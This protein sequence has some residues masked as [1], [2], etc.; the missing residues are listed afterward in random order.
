LADGLTV[1]LAPTSP[2]LRR[3]RLIYTSSDPDL[4]AVGIA[5][6]GRALEHLGGLSAV[7]GWTLRLP[8]VRHIVEFLTFMVPLRRLGTRL[9][10][11]L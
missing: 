4:D 5:A 1:N 2:S 11:G 9:K 3:Q 10:V 6:L 7:L 8:V